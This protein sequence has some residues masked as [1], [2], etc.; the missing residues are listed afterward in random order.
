MI[1]TVT[2][3]AP[4]FLASALVNGDVSGINDSHSDM[5]MYHDVLNYLSAN[6]LMVVSCGDSF[7]SWSFD[8]H[9]GD[10][11]GGDL[12]EYVCYKEIT[13]ND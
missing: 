1:E 7:F 10:C 2:V 8:Q 5:G 13:Q 6:G 11:S 4:A 9:F 3:I 12:C